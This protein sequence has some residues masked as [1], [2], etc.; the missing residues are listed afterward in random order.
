MTT[1]KRN[2]MRKDYKNFISY[3]Q[4]VTT[5]GIVNRCKSAEEAE[6]KANMKLKKSDFMCGVMG[7]TPFELSATEEWNPHAK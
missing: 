7:R 2:A 5:I 3:F 6:K 4:S 1:E